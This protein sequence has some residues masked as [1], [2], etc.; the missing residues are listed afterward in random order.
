MAKTVVWGI[1][2][3]RSWLTGGKIS[4]D[5]AWVHHI[6]HDPITGKIL[7]GLDYENRFSCFAAVKGNKEN[8]EVEGLD[9]KVHEDRFVYMWEQFR[10]GNYKEATNHWN[11]FTPHRQADFLRERRS[12]NYLDNWLQKLQTP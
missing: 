1:S 6:M 12:L 7:Y 4:Y 11:R 5:E 3:G 10:A 9:W 2:G 8:K